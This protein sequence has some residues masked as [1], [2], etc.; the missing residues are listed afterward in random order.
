MRKRTCIL[1]LWVFGSGLVG[2]TEGN[3]A[4]GPAGVANR[5]AVGPKVLS[6]PDRFNDE[7]RYEFDFNK[8][9]LQ[10]SGLLLEAVPVKIERETRIR[11][12]M[13][14]VPGD[15]DKGIKP[16]YLSTTEVP[17]NMF[18]PWATGEGLERKELEQW[19]SYS[20]HPSQISEAAR[21]QGPM[22]RPALG[23]SRRAAELYCEWLSAQTGRTYRLPTEA[24]WEHALALAGGVPVS[25]SALLKRAT[26]RDNAVVQTDPP[27]LMLPSA[28]GQREPVKLGL[29]DLL[30]NAAE[31]VS[32][33]G[34]QRVVRGGHFQLAAEELTAD[35]RVVEDLSAWNATYPQR[36]ISGYWY[37]DQAFTGIRLACD[38]DQ[39]PAAVDRH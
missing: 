19:W 17:A 31:W 13:T 22:N 29:Y 36:P 10:G 37:Y 3:E 11:F 21:L 12:E 33:T 5:L 38:A 7:V 34:K 6:G 9:D 24:E 27:F 14:R 30:G 26:L 35:W 18:Y 4:G 16:F 1:L 25:K 8:K 15:A 23:M 20:L 32:D 28:I 39:A 2:C